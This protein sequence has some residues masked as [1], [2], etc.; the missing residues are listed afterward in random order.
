MVVLALLKKPLR[1]FHRVAEN[2]DLVS[3]RYQTST[4]DNVRNNNDEPQNRD[5]LQC[6]R[7]KNAR[8]ERH[9]DEGRK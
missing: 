1:S 5:Q 9:N 3:Y 2:C 8:D 7:D 6:D 4:N